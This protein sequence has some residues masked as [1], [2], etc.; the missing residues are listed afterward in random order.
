MAQDP[1]FKQALQ[2]I[3]C[4]SC[5]NVCPVF[6]LVGGHVFGSVYTGGIGTILT[7][8]FDE[9]KK[10]EDI[11]GLCIQCGKCNEVCPGKIDIAG[12]ILELRKRLAEKQGI[13]FVQKAI[14]SVVN[15]RRLFHSMLRAAY[16][17][18]QPFVEDG[19]IRHLPMFLSNITKDRSLFSIA[20]EPFR[21]RFHNIEQP[22]CTEK[23]SFY[24]GCLMDFGYPGMGEAL[25]RILNKAGIQVVFTEKQTCCGAP[26][27]MSG[28]TDVAAN[29]AIDNIEALDDPSAKYIVC[30]CPTCTVAL[31][32][33]F[34]RVLQDQGK[35]EWIDKAKT[36]ASKAIDFTTLVRQLISDGRLKLKQNESLGKVTY[37]DSCHYKRSLHA[38]KAPREVL[39]L[40]GFDLV[41]MAESDVCCGMGGSYSA[42][43]PEVSGPILK[44]KLHNI[45][46]TGAKLVATD[47]PGCV[48]Q[49]RGGF[50]KQ[51]SEIDVKHTIEVL[52][53]LIE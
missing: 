53:K 34:L 10:S 35:T 51:K 13:P 49:L 52:D 50:N 20:A 41:E 8:W 46:E 15:N 3:R 48:M 1:K 27:R 26:A 4:A 39:G 9:L 16:V 31:K 11:Q 32:E 6:R 18:Q 45:D 22:Q 33:D 44:R 19:Y 29:N 12:L 37:H 24:A 42:K 17:G 5:L 36:I 2:C 38:E 14:F 40:G 23:A 30:A 43:H 28:A 7:A 21:D 25:V 47:C